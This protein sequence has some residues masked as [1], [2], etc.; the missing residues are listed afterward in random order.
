[1]IVFLVPLGIGLVVHVLHVVCLVYIGLDHLSTFDIVF[2]LRFVVVVV[3][4]LVSFYV[5][6]NIGE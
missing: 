5:L 4:V 6:Y 3:F 2:L 1:M